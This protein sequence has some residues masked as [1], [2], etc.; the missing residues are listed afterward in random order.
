MKMVRYGIGK[1]ESTTGIRQYKREI[2]QL[3]TYISTIEK[4]LIFFS[5]KRKLLIKE[6]KRLES[7]KI[8]PPKD[9]IKEFMENN[10]ILVS[11]V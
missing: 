7:N 11:N 3:N 9:H 4:K 5:F 1:S 10:E 2:S 6:L 8:I